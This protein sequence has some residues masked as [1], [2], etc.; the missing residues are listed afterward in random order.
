MSEKERKDQVT[1][2]QDEPRVGDETLRVDRV[3]RLQALDE[4]RKFSCAHRTLRDFFYHR[5]L[6]DCARF[7]GLQS[8]LRNSARSR[9]VFDCCILR[10]ACRGFDVIEHQARCQCLRFRGFARIANSRWYGTA[11]LRESAGTAVARLLNR[12]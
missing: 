1:V 3:T 5:S 2:L 12:G 9:C 10:R 6:L 8:R 11:A 7:R 4:Y